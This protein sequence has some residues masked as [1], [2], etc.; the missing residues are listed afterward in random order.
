[1]TSV[2]AVVVGV[3]AP[4]A[5]DGIIVVVVVAPA[6]AAVIVVVVVVPQAGEQR[7]AAVYSEGEALEGEPPIA[8]FCLR[9]CRGD[10]LRHQRRRRRRPRC[11]GALPERDARAPRPGATVIGGSCD[12]W[13]L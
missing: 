8:P 11:V 1:M 9:R 3:D 7:L 12:G 2:C 10:G 6:L 13:R 4:A 5:A